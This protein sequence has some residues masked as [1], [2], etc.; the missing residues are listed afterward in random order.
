LLQQTDG[1]RDGSTVVLRGRVGPF[2]I[3]MVFQHSGYNPPR[4]FQD[5]QISGPFHSWFH[6]HRFI[7]G[8]DEGTTCLLQDEVRYALPAGPVGDFVN[9]LW[10]SR[11]IERIF[12]YRHGVTYLD[13]QRLE[14]RGIF[15]PQ[16]ILVAGSSG[17]VGSA[18]VPFLRTCGHSVTRLVRNH[19]AHEPDVRLWKPDAGE[20]DSSAMADVDTVIHLGGSSILAPRWNEETRRRIRESRI[21]ST[22][23]LVNAITSAPKPPKTFICASAVGIYGNTPE[24]DRFEDAPV[25]SGYLADVAKDWEAAANYAAE[26]GVRVVNLRIGLVL[27]ASGGLLGKSLLPFQLA[28][29]GRLGSGRQQMSWVSLHDLLYAVQHLLTNDRVSGPVNMTAPK[30]VSNA[31]FTSTLGRI[32]RRPTLLSPSEGTLRLLFGEFADEVLLSGVSAPP[33]KLTDS[34][35]QFEFKELED[36]IRFDLGLLR[37]A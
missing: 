18:L 21:E 15:T 3:P 7:D 34:G 14:D 32:L 24:G 8:N 19:V 13:V 33:G 9:E 10:F 11:E 29:G 31:E 37:V 4:E 6:S 30:S 16:K 35:F 28:L 23:L 17:M 20:F 25:G 1:L 22:R 27:S 5:T 2:K 12:T 26:A 36:A